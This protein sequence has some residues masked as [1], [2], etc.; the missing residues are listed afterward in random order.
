MKKY[1][2]IGGIVGVLTLVSCTKNYVCSCDI[3]VNTNG[4]TTE[5]PKQDYAFND[6]KKKVAIDSCNAKDTYISE[7]NVSTT[8]NCELK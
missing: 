6:M 2:L 8:T 1:I 5:A 7:G 3:Q 4:V